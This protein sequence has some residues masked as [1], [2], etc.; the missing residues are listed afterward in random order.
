MTFFQIKT[1]RSKIT[2]KP[3][4]NKRKSGGFFLRFKAYHF[5]LTE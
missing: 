5:R 3:A 1:M 2:K 4:K